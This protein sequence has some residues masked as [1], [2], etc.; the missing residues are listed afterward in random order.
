[1]TLSELILAVGDENVRLQNLDQS[2][3]S[4]NWDAKR[5][6]VIKFSTSE[7]L[8]LDGTSRLGL[9]IWL[10]RDAAKAALASK[11][12]DTVLISQ[13]QA[14]RTALSEIIKTRLLGVRPEDQDITLEDADWMEIIATLEQEKTN[15]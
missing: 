9:V 4:L 2:S 1:M 11:Q 13:R 7:P 14:S 8:T 5:G 15:G 10:D 6:T 3:I 12:R